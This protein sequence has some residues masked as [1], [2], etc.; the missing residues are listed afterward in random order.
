MDSN[1]QWQLSESDEDEGDIFDPYESDPK[2]ETVEELEEFLAGCDLSKAAEIGEEKIDYELHQSVQKVCTCGQCADIW[3]DGFE[4]VCCQ[5][6]D[7]S[8]FF[9]LTMIGTK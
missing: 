8:G 2:F 1:E 5:Q 3:S 7:R 6:T 9:L 4:H